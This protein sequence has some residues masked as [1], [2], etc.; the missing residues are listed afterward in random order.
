MTLSI[1]LGREEDNW[2]TPRTDCLKLLV[3][4]GLYANLCFAVYGRSPAG[5][6]GGVYLVMTP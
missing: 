1:S 2:D 6:F 5:S 4:A 3:V